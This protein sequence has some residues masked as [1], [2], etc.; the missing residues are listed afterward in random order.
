MANNSV[1]INDS[2]Y[3]EFQVHS[4]VL[5][6]LIKSPS[7]QR[8]KGISQFG[9][10]D[11]YYH[12]HGYSRF[13]HSI[14]VMRLLQILGAGVEEQVA[15]LLHDVSHAAFSHV[16]DWVVGSNTTEDWQD[17]NLA[18]YIAQSELPAILEK[19]GFDPVRIS[20]HRFFP[21]LEQEMPDLCADRIDYTF[22]E[23]DPCLARLCLA[24]L[25]VYQGK[26]VFTDRGAALKFSEKY[27][28]LQE[29]HWGGFEAVSRYHLLGELLRYALDSGLVCW[30]DFW[31]DDEYILS[32]LKS[33]SQK[34][35]DFVLSV[36]EKKDLSRLPISDKAELKKFR[37]VDP[38]VQENYS[39]QRL[40]ELSASFAK[41]LDQARLENEKGIFSVDIRECKR[42]DL[43]G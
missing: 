38:L 15:G 26:V 22:R 24:S 29:G 40:S 35:I 13:E 32:K 20:D 11:K 36:L 21:I 2:V 23:M 43:A 42:R 4:P 19:H 31:Q 39:V 28:D 3:G 34:R 12:L 5:I 30:D 16:V 7:V 41:K 9:L 17:A 1:T 27:L 10:P 18:R 33:A 6:E 8:L 37:F 25:S 14:G